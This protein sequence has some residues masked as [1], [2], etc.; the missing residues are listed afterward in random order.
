MN[1]VLHNAGLHNNTCRLLLLFGGT[2]GRLDIR[3]THHRQVGLVLFGERLLQ[4]A[5]VLGLQLLLVLLLLKTARLLCLLLLVLRLITED[6]GVHFI[7]CL[8]EVLSRG[9]ELL[10]GLLV[11]AFHLKVVQHVF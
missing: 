5:K 3:Q 6:L 11:V 9:L 10:F 4:Q 2:Q 7:F 8:A 1:K